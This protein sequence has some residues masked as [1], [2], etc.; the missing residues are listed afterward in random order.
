MIVRLIVV[1]SPQVTGFDAS[2]VLGGIYGEQSGS[3]T[4]FPGMVKFRPAIVIPPMLNTRAFA[5]H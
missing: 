2:S 4:G 3:V 5:Y 1:F